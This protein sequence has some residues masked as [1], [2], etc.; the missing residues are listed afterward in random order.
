MM[1][2]LDT[3]F[4]IRMLDRGT[5]EAR[6]LE[7]LDPEESVVVSAVAWAEFLCGPIKRAE[8]DL[9]LRIV[10]SHRDLTVEHAGIAARLFNES[11][12]R[13]NSLSDCMI[14]AIAIHDG[15]RLATANH[16]D[17]R[18]FEAAGLKLA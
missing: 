10:D 9:A 6:F 17:F 4:L 12:R 18:R 15:A 7:A 13:R 1:I 2:H 5:P 14:A 3:S 16:A 8:Q 11:G